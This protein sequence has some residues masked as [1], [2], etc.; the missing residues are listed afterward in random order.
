MSDGATLLRGFLDR[1][2][3]TQKAAS[4]ALDVSDPTINDWVNG[5]KRPRAH[6]R[7]AIA[8][9]TRG[10]VPAS[11][12]LL[13][14]EAEKMANVRPFERDESSRDLGAGDSGEIPAVIVPRSDTG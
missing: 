14:A 13:E 1:N 9:W 8:V 7:D 6:H 4:I 12:W 5:A 2:D 11:A 3:V 10:E